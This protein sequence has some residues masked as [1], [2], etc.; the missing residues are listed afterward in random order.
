MAFR[1]PGKIFVVVYCYAMVII[2]GLLLVKN[3][4][5]GRRNGEEN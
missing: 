4:F 3:S 2:S 5:V 1:K